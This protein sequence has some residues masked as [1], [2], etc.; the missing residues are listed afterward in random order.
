M[1]A[2]IPFILASLIA[3]PALAAPPDAFGVW[4]TANR[5]AAIE[6]QPCGTTACG[7]L[8]WYLEKRSGPDAGLDSK[9]PSPEQRRRRL[10]GIT[11]LGGFKPS[12]TGWEDGWVYDPESGN[13]YS[14]TMEPDGPD[15]LRLRG[16]VGIPLFGRTEVWS[17]APANQQRCR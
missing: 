4:L 10:C 15:R 9:N 11:M 17:R 5:E 8:V 3:T 16:Y 13:T 6:V 12:A 2:T 14:G 1:R 7:R